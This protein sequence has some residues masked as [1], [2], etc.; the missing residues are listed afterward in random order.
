MFQ[1]DDTA[2]IEC[3][4][5]NIRDLIILKHDTEKNVLAVQLFGNNGGLSISK[6]RHSD[7]VFLHIAGLDLD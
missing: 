4:F 6:N 5:Y 7:M 3:F 2:Q 1:R